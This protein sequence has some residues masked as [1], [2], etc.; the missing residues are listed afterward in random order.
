MPGEINIH[1]KRWLMFMPTILFGVAIDLQFAYQ[2]KT[3][4]PKAFVDLPYPIVRTAGYIVS[5]ASLIA[6]GATIVLSF[7]T[8]A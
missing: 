3:Y 1:F 6:S 5:F 2:V 8:F 4:K 7:L